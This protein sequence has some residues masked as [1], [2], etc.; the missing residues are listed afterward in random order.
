MT[1]AETYG[2]CGGNAV[3]IRSEFCPDQTSPGKALTSPRALYRAA[4][5]AR[6]N[7]AVR[8]ILKSAG[9][10]LRAQQH[11]QLVDSRCERVRFERRGRGVS[12]VTRATTRNETERDN[13]GAASSPCDRPAIL[14]GYVLPKCSCCAAESGSRR[15][16]AGLPDRCVLQTNYMKRNGI[17]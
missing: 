5:A 13:P 9:G 12:V 3:T 1:Q 14:V 17:R 7:A 11:L 6:R 16:K 2:P 4:G 15:N 8:D 10:K